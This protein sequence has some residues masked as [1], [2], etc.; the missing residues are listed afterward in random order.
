MTS[1]RCGSGVLLSLLR[2][3]QQ[4]DA[5]EWEAVADRWEAH[6]ADRAQAVRIGALVGLAAFRGRAFLKQARALEKAEKNATV[7]RVLTRTV[8]KLASD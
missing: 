8:A 1:A 5:R 2:H 6:L 3:R 4:L 7:R